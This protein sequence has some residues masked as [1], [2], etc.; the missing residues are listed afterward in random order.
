MRSG[1]RGDAGKKSGYYPAEN[2][3]ID[4]TRVAITADRTNTMIARER[5]FFSPLASSP[6]QSR[7]T[8]PFA[9]PVPPPTHPLSAPVPP[10][11][12]VA[13]AKLSV[14]GH[15]SRRNKRRASERGRKGMD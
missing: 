14:R 4:K 9:D 8:P 10:L 7:F 5:N 3:G 1:E 12:C 11:S 15:K 6:C 2:G 13:S